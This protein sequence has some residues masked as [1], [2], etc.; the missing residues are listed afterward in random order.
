MTTTHSAIPQ[1]TPHPALSGPLSHFLG[2]A[3]SSRPLSELNGEKVKRRRDAFTMRE[4]VWG[5]VIDRPLMELNGYLSPFDEVVE[6][7]CDQNSPVTV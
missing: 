7:I 2:D 6:T 3:W 4:R 5:F 1:V